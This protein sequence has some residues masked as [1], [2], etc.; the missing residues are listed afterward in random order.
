M[1]RRNQSGKVE[2]GQEAEPGQYPWMA[3]LLRNGQ[4]QFCGGVLLD[5]T[6]IL[7]A[8]HCVYKYVRTLDVEE[9]RQ[10]G[11]RAA[12]LGASFRTRR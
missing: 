8:A 1:R 9:N 2:G 3:A 10:T 5:S 6:H 4:Q 12:R 11:A 7:T